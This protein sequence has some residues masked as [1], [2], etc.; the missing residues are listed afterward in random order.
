MRPTDICAQMRECEHTTFPWRV[1]SVRLSS[2]QSL[3]TV[4]FSALSAKLSSAM[5]DAYMVVQIWEEPSVNKKCNNAVQYVQ[6]RK[7]TH[8]NIP[9]LHDKQPSLLLVMILSSW[10]PSQQGR[11]ALLGDDSAKVSLCLVW[12]YLIGKVVLLR[13]AL[14]IDWGEYTL[15]CL[16]SHGRSLDGWSAEGGN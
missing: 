2:P 11:G 16:V 3:V 4:V 7:G 5:G 8:I 12:G 9:I 1:F 6:M 13:E 14:T 15:F 10:Q